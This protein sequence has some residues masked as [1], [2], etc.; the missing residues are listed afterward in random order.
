ME[1]RITQVVLSAIEPDKLEQK[2]QEVAYWVAELRKQMK[3]RIREALENE[4]GNRS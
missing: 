4:T 2:V 3:N 1:N